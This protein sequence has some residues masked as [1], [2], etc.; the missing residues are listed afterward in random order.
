MKYVD[1]PEKGSL[2]VNKLGWVGVVF[3]KPRST[4]AKNPYA[5]AGIWV[6][7]DFNEGGSVYLSD[8]VTDEQGLLVA[9]FQPREVLQFFTISGQ[10]EYIIERYNETHKKAKTGIVWNEAVPNN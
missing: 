7:G 10:H 1:K 4:L 9:V 6:A 2:V 8:L 5:T 3:E